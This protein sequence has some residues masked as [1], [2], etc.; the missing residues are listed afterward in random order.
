MNSA[1][2]RDFIIKE[3]EENHTVKILELSRQLKVTRETI[4]KDLY[5]LEKKGIIK[6]VHG[7]AVLEI[8]NQET[9]Y[10][11]RKNEF[12]D[13]KA[14]IAKKAA[15]Y[16]EEG[17]TVYLD[18]GTT[19]LALAK[20]IVKMKN[21]TVVTNTIPIVNLLLKNKTIHLIMP[22]GIV[23]NNESS[24]YGPFASNNIKEIYVS[25]GFFGCSGIDM[26]R[27]ITSHHTGENLVSKE[28]IQHSQTTVILADHSKFGAV[29]F[30]RT[31]TF[32]Q[33]DI[34]ITDQS[35]N[36]EE[37]QQLTQQGVELIDGSEEE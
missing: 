21:L 8:S 31:A 36:K 26:E 6:K 13:E 3:L 2:R 29:A 7:G 18:Y 9:D 15:S 37:Q 17:D 30:N 23:R 5:F 32:D 34:V 22:G 19:T 24:L 16:I 33:V 10:E 27:G 12:H 11:K 14:I 25:I 28:M 20:E 1:A 35:R 4:R